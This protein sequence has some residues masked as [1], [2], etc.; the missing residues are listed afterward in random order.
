MTQNVLTSDI[1]AKEALMILDNNLI[2]AN[3][4]YRGYEDEFD[5]Q[6]NGYKKG[7]TVSVRRPAQFTV[8]RGE[9]AQIQE[10]KE[11][12][13]QIAVNILDGVDFKFTSTDLTL[14]IDELGERVM[15]PA[16]LQLANN[17][18]MEIWKLYR[19]VHN[20]AG[21]PGQVINSFADFGKGPERLDKL[22][23]PQDERSAVMSP[24]DYWGMLGSQ[25]GLFLQNPG[26]DAY[27]R[28]KLGMIGGVDSY[29]AQNVQTHTVGD[30]A[31]TGT[32]LVNGA[33]Q[34]TT[35]ES[36]KD[37]NTQNLVTDGWGNAKTLRQGD[38]FTIAGM[39]AVNPVTKAVEDYLQQ[40]VVTADVI[41]HAA[42]GNTTIP[43]AP[44]II[45]SGAYQ[46]VSAAPA[47][48]AAVTVLGT[49][50]TPY[51]QNMV[52]HKNAFAL[53][54]VP[55]EMPAG[56]VGGARKSYNGLSVRVVPTWDGINNVSFWRL[57]VLYGVKAIDTRLATRL[58]GSP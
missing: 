17:I 50:G 11:G 19:Q 42:G 44:A 30:A 2:G 37:T 3:L 18:D 45:A 16:L 14:K 29:M 8:R 55:L 48:N 9:T 6:V 24:A 15:K 12:K 52:F 46:T 41:T 38:V 1:I 36:V 25:S 53:T 43:I 20:W 5:R 32:P 58:S 31:G 10:V 39:F 47:D 40:F 22:A 49:A 27:R 28:A 57:D 54:M 33:N 23:V 21:T 26:N 4:V 56:S 7:D 34:D 35:Y 13:F 51:K